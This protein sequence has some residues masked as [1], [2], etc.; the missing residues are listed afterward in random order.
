VGN[1]ARPLARPRGKGA[2]WLCPSACCKGW[3]SHVQSHATAAAPGASASRQGCA[4]WGQCCWCGG[5]DRQ[6]EGFG[7]GSNGCLGGRAAGRRSG[8][9]GRCCIRGIIG[10]VRAS[11]CRAGRRGRY[12]IRGIIGAVRASCCRAGRRG[13]CCISCSRSGRLRGCHCISTRWYCIAS[14]ASILP[15][16]GNGDCASGRTCVIGSEWGRYIRRGSCRLRAG[17]GRGLRRAR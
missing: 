16:S 12:C 15:E 9:R 8:R 10:A 4:A 14:D 13:R 5:H 2:A 11:C 17:P 6:R 7:G 3:H 1:G